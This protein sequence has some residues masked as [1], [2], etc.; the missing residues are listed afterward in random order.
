MLA[1]NSLEC[2]KRRKSLCLLEKMAVLGYNL[3][4]L[5]QASAHGEAWPMA[6]KYF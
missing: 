3:K 6:D 1:L 2:Q 4:H 5:S